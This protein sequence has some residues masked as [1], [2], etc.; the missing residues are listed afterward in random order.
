[1]E[2]L[3]SK[4][5]VAQAAKLKSSNP[6][7]GILYRLSGMEKVNDFYER[8]SHLKDLEFV[9]KSLEHIGLQVEVDREELKHIPEDGAFIT[10]SNHPYG[11]IDGI[12]LMHVLGNVRPDFKVLVNFL[13]QNI[14]QIKGR[15][16]GV[17]PFN[18]HQSSKSNLAG[19]K[20]AI[21]HIRD[22]HP[23]GIFPAGEVSSFNPEERTIADGQWSPQVVKL[24][25]HSNVPVIPIYFDGRNSRLFHLLGVI[26]PSLRTLRLPAEFSNKRGK[27]LKL[28]IGKPIKA[29]DLQG[30]ENTAQLGRYLRSKTYALGTPLDVKREHFKGLKFPKKPKEV[31]PAV[32]KKLLIEDIRRSA[33][34]KLFDYQNFECYLLNASSNPHVLREIGRLR[35]ITFR[36]VG[37]GT[38]KAIDIDEYDFYY[39]H[40]VL[41]DKEK[42]DIVGAY[43]VGKGEEI[44][45]RY[46]K[47]GF[48]TNS[49]FKMSSEMKPILNESIEL[50][51]SFITQ[52][53]QRQRMPLFLL[54]K[55]ILVVLIKESK[56]RYILGPV[57]I[58][59]TYQEV[60]KE[61][62]MEFVKRN[63]FDDNLSLHIKPRTPYSVKSK[64]VDQDALLNATEND[65]KK[66]D[67]LISEI[68]PSSYTIPVLL[69]KY[70]HQN[71]R[72]LGFNLDPQFN[73]A[74]DGLMLLDIHNL[75]A[76]TIENLQREF[77][78]G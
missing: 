49:L 8:I 52:E 35:E 65:L 45:S 43:R 70:L 27:T 73:N 77:S 1:M 23:L 18:D 15:L 11:A 12:A 74:L 75:P 7:V 39:Y 13:L 10:V 44:M 64:R 3:V 24:I 58:S 16:I 66:L 60:S 25:K 6:L 78:E 20:E 47:K 36:G 59:G 32:D 55:G 57:T 67:R 29:K 2:K 46:G 48:Y 17:N 4:E 62:I 50:G 34:D 61:L 63:Y 33:N 76:E 42:N 14:D 31:I 30:F 51:R 41:W 26:H 5:Q 40:L 71:A 54:W 53:Y 21:Q 69:K 28:R 22:G 9:A 37:E 68:E 38:N 56:H 72:I 19:T